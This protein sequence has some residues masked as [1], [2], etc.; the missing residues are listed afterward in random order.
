MIRLLI[1]RYKKTCATSCETIQSRLKSNLSF[2][3]P[4]WMSF[5]KFPNI[6][7][8]VI[9]LF[10]EWWER[11]AT[12]IG[13]N[14][15]CYLLPKNVKVVSDKTVILD[16]AKCVKIPWFRNR[17]EIGRFFRSQLQKIVKRFSMKIKFVD[18]IVH[19]EWQVSKE[20]TGNAA[21]RL[22]YECCIPMARRNRFIWV[23][24]LTDML[25]CEVFIVPNQSQRSLYKLFPL[26]QTVPH[27]WFGHWYAAPPES[28]THTM[29]L[30]HR[31]FLGVEVYRL[32]YVKR[33]IRSCSHWIQVYMI[34]P[35]PGLSPHRF[36][37]V[38]FIAQANGWGVKTSE[39]DHN[40]Y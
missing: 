27:Q 39:G 8:K 24:F 21:N 10:H 3:F 22:R 31:T 2:Y 26:Q 36:N 17:Q 30:H 11:W 29:P 19:L 6:T 35:M 28:P 15:P 9:R 1:G 34:G 5:D 40:S 4:V 13:F 18:W 33:L 20:R 38:I 23:S 16:N 25:Q 37:P 7:W 32:C 12:D 14:G